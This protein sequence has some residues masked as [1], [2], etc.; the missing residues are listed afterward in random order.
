MSEPRPSRRRF[1]F[2]LSRLFLLMTLVSVL[3]A[4]GAGLMRAKDS[5]L[6]GFVLMLVAAPL[7]TMI[8]L[9]L[10]FALVRLFSSRR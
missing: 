5:E 4:A 1:Q 10:W 9:S 8:V 3:S 2:P 7:A 6:P